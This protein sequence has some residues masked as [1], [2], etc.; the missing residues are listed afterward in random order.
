MS[1]HVS[2]PTIDDT[3]G[4]PGTLSSKVLTGLL[5]DELHFDGLV[6]TDS[7]E[8]GA[9]GRSGFP[10]PR[11]AARALH[12]GA[13]LL[14]F[15]AGFQLHQAA[16]AQIAADIRAGTIPLARLDEAVRR[17]LRAKERFGLT[18]PAPADPANA[19]VICAAPAHRALAA[20]LAVESVSLLRDPAA[21]LPLAKSARPI[22]IAV[23]AG[24][25]LA[26][27]LGGSEVKVAD[28]PTER[29][30]AAALA[31]VRARR[32][33]PVIITLAGANTNRRQT[34]LA[35]KIIAT[36]ASVILVALREPYDLMALAGDPAA[37]TAPT[38][39][40]TYGSNPPGTLPALAA[41]LRGETKPAGHLPVELPGLLPLGAGM[42][43][44]VQR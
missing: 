32:D 34:E 23:P 41:V 40:A 3:P 7:L 5:R 31:A 8:M 24:V 25:K 38:L 30:V 22:V 26:A 21:R 44:F 18:Q 15:N 36:G 29:E 35:Q 27:L 1:A 14:L 33:A 43:A 19:A 20:R 42:D 11:A 37:R 16:I 10:A 4:L 9:L 28:T 12:A 13:D 17:V 6:A 39:V 2:F